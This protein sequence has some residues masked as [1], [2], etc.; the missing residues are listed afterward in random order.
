MF[1]RK[2]N[3]LI[4][5][6]VDNHISVDIVVSVMPVSC[7]NGMASDFLAVLNSLNVGLFGTTPRIP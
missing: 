3:N 1:A 2:L 6:R 4:L 7:D 5:D